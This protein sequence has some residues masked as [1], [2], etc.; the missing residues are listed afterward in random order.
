MQTRANSPSRSG[1][2][3]AAHER[4]YGWVLNLG[5]VE[6]ERAL[7]WQHGL[8]KMR[9]EG[10]ARDVIVLVEHPPVVT[11][12]RDG[13][14]ENFASLERSPVY[15][16]RGG[17]VTYHGPGQLVAYFIFNLTRRG[18]DLHQ[19]MANLQQGIIATLADY[20]VEARRGDEYTGVW[21]GEKKIAS[22]GVA[23]KH[24]ITFH[25][26]A[27]NLNTNLSDFRAINPCG[28]AADVM[29]SLEQILGRTVD[30]KEFGTRLIK[31]YETVFNTQF[32]G[33]SL[34]SLAEDIESQ[35]GG[36]EI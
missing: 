21:V 28:L 19:F 34:E 33:I 1:R 11:V 31:K 12:G 35:K 14:K 30:M 23:V 8:V 3:A 2:E 18:R 13:H 4:R 10:F 29:T 17:D 24:W 27:I 15:I 20:H 6:F 16:E 9:R 32:D 25:G 36:G 7:A 26:A 22:L 5:R